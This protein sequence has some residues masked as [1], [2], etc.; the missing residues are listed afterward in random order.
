IEEKLEEIINSQREV[1]EVKEIEG[2]ALEVWQG[3]EKKKV[4][5]GEIKGLERDEIVA[6]RVVKQYERER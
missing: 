6:F 1:K 5:T 4:F 2:K 3:K